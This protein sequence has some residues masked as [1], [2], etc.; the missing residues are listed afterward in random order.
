AP[1][2]PQSQ[3]PP[4]PSTPA[5]SRFG[6]R[7]VPAVLDALIPGLG[8]LAAGRRRR[9]IVFLAPVFIVL[10]VGAWI[11]LT[12]SAPR[13]VAEL[14]ASE[15][16]WGLLAIQGLFLVWRL[17]AVGSSI[18]NPALPR[19]GKRDVLPVALVLLLVLVPQAFGG[20]ATEVAR[21]TTD[22]ILVYPRTVD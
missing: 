9:A 13:L 6:S 20:Y 11:V 5:S 18:W 16:I 21:E 14:L 8:H 7:Y 2:D 12:T 1:T 10:I 15:V 3:T 4:T 22:E 19:P 17:V